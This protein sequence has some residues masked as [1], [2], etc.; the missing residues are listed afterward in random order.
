MFIPGRLLRSRSS[1]GVTQGVAQGLD[2]VVDVVL[3]Q[4]GRKGQRES[5]LGDPAG[6]RKV[7]RSVAERFSVI[8]VKVQRPKVSPGPD[9][10]FVKRFLHVVPAD[11][12]PL[13]VRVFSPS[14]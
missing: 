1:D 14:T 5:A 11:T 10:L 4:L 2:H 9:V 3:G 12:Q 6:V 13:S 8:A 7:L